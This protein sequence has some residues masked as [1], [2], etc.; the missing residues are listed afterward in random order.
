M[1]MQGGDWNRS[2]RSFAQRYFKDA[3]SPRHQSLVQIGIGIAPI[4]TRCPRI[5]RRYHWRR[6]PSAVTSIAAGQEREPRVHVLGATVQV[7][8]DLEGLSLAS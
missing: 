3:G 1:M 4:G 2:E 8:M 6:L 7:D 5:R